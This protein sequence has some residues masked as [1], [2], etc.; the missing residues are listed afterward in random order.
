M[1]SQDGSFFK[2]FK[3][4][5]VRALSDILHR[6]TIHIVA[7]ALCFISDKALLLGLQIVLNYEANVFDLFR[8]K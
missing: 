5:A 4:L 7:V 3:T 2:S 6:D 8:L 1:N